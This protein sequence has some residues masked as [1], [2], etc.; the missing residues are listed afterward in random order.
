MDNDYELNIDEILR[1]VETA[2]VVTFRFVVIGQRLLV[3]SRSTAIDGPL[4]K[5]VSAVKSPE[6]RF[7]SLKQLRPRFRLPEKICAVW[8]PKHIQSLVTSGVWQ[9]VAKRIIDSGHPGAAQ[10]CE[11]VLHELLLQEEEEVRSAIVGKGYQA[12]WECYSP[13]QPRRS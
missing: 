11:E 10:Q 12:L 5:L 6:E 13:D 7:R 8:W 3:D 9:S 4:L 2:E 1:T